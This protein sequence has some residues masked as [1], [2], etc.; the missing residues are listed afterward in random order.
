MKSDPMRDIIT[1]LKHN[2]C[3][4][5]GGKKCQ[6]NNAIMA[7]HSSDFM[8]ANPISIRADLSRSVHAFDASV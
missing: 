8:P 3:K 1:T 5:P 7:K 6:S 2:I 4:I